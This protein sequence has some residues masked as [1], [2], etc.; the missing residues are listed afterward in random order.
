[1]PD[2]P[3]SDLTGPETRGIPFDNLLNM[4]EEYP[5]LSQ[6]LDSAMPTTKLSPVVL[7][8]GAGASKPLGMPT[9]LEFKDNYSKR[10]R[11]KA[12]TLWNNVVDSSAKF[13]N[14]RANV[15]DLEQ[16]LTYIDNCELSYCDSMSMWEKNVWSASWL[17]DD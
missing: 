11:G 2:S 10:V 6:L 14:T 8:T 5:G 7:F 3:S 15:I 16:V 17:A 9:M 1:M 4:S 12:A 13:F